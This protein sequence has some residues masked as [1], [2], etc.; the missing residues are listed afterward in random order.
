MFGKFQINKVV[1]Y[2]TLSDVFTWGIYYVFS[3]IAAIYL[4]TKF[5]G[6]VLKYIGIGTSVY[7]V[8][9][10]AFQLPIG[11]LC[12]RIQKDRDEIFLLMVGNMLMG[13]SYLMYPVITTP[14]FFLFLQFVFGM[15]AAFNLVTWRKLFA[16]NLDPGREG[17]EYAGYETIM[18]GM[19]AFFGVLTGY[20]ANLGE[21]QFES[22]VFVLGGLMLFSAVFPLLLFYVKRRK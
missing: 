15:G 10:A 6:D 8:T 19:T 7:F 17:K 21:A 14:S 4:A 3:S 18:S 22:L 11:T 9:R 2:L 16:R 1:V 5:D 13:T 20:I 12:D